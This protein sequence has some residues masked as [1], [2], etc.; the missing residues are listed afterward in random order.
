[1]LD[2]MR[3][4]KRLKAIL[5]VVIFSLALGMLLF[6][7]PGVN[8]GN[9]VS[10]T[11]AAS[12]DGDKISMAEF[13][14]AYQRLVERYTE[15]QQS[16]LDPE[17]LRSMGLPRQVLDN[18]INFRVIGVIADRLGVKVTPEEVRKAIEAYPAFQ[19]QGKF[20]G[21]E[22]YKELLRA[23]KY[24][25]ADFEDDIYRAQLVKKVKEVLTDSLD[26][27]DRELRYEFAK[28]TQKTVMEYVMLKKDDFLKRIKPNEADLRAYF[29]SHKDKY[30]IK[31]KRRI[32]YLLIPVS[33]LAPTINVTEQQILDEWERT[34]HQETAEAAH[35]LFRVTDP[36]KD[37]EVKAK[38]EAVLKRAKAGEDFAALAKKYSEDTSNAKEG[39]R[40]PPFTKSDMVKEFSDAAFS[41]KPNEISDLVRTQFGYHIIKG[42]GVQTPTLESNRLSL[43]TAI[44]LRKAQEMA[45]QK[46]EEAATMAKTQSDLSAVAKNLGVPAEIRDTAPFGI[47]DNPYDLGISQAMRD[48]VFQLKN[49][50]AI[51]KPSEHPLGIAIPKLAEVQLPKP[52]V[53]ELSRSEV[54][55]DYLESKAKEMT[56]AEA[57]KL[58]NEAKKLG[59]LEKAAKEMGLSV[60]TSQEF[61]VGGTPDPEI[62]TNNALNRVAFDLPPG[63]ISDPQPLLDNFAIFQVKSHSPFDEPAFQ[64]AKPELQKRMLQALQDPYFQEYVRGVM[65]E[66]EK[67]GDIRINGK[68]LEQL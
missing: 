39:G 48:E 58:S 30:R 5:W 53:F 14:K 19:D 21:I 42:L 1:M 62:G 40:L 51:G 4:K 68:A 34:P 50:N 10:D 17:T 22:R 63:S 35:I 18:L 54:E 16:Q 3:R 38:A 29:E 15:N 7:I 55:K 43:T 8:V 46:A 65:D 61:V 67:A 64:K 28:D 32:Q 37:A 60:K 44:Q 20:I 36:S 31:E 49:I 33:R 25:I 2:L 45:K 11:S 57:N 27:T 9:V 26:V 52:G 47:D 12:V 66:L 13:R 41:L 59:S 6:F 23:N 56:Q 24:S